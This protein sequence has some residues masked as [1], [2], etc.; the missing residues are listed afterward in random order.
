VDGVF[1]GGTDA[2]VRSF[3]RQAD[4]DVDGLVGPVTWKALFPGAAMIRPSLLDKPLAFRCLALSASFETNAGPPDCFAGISGDFDGQGISFGALQ[5]NFGQGSLQPLLTEMND[6]RPDIM[7]VVFGDNMA[8]VVQVLTSS[9]QDQMAWARSIQDPHGSRIHEPWLGQFRALGRRPEFQDIEVRHA[10]ALHQQAE[11]LCQRFGLGSQRG[12]ALMFDIKV[13]NGSI[14][15]VVEAQIRLDFSRLPA[16]LQG[17]DLEVARLRSIA[18][19]RAE[20][21]APRWVKD[22]RDRKLT[23][24]NGSGTV[25]GVPYDLANDYGIDLSPAEALASPVPH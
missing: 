6:A 15:A 20:A 21:A 5:W 14:N 18:T 8:V 2:A 17:D 10:A 1:G 23:I 13:Q 7:Q 9:L 3:Q 24:A 4:L 22:V 25:H 12:V 16:S 19:R 11:A